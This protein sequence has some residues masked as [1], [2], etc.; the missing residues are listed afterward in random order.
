[1][2]LSNDGYDTIADLDQNGIINVVDIIVIINI[3]LN[4]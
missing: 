2:I 4:L 1:M 3:I